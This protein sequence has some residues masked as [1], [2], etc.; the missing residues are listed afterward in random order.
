MDVYGSLNT[1][2]GK[3]QGFKEDGDGMYLDVKSEDYFSLRPG[4]GVEGEWSYTTAKGSKFMLM[5]GAA[6]E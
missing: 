1:G 3:F 5:A 4:A 6:Y 2:Y